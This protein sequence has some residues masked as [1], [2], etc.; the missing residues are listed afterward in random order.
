MLEQDVK[1]AINV[2]GSN[3]IKVYFSGFFLRHF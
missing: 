1:E 3:S 2:L